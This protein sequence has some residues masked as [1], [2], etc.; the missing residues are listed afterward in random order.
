M[1]AAQEDDVREVDALPRESLKIFRFFSSPIRVTFLK[2]TLVPWSFIAGV[3][4]TGA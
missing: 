3:R 1:N 2:A 4:S